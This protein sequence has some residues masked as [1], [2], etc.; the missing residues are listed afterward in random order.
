MG[1]RHQSQNERIS[2]LRFG[3][4]ASTTDDTS[5]HPTVDT[6]PKALEEGVPAEK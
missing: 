1:F 4:V 3:T 2:A 6:D 5:S